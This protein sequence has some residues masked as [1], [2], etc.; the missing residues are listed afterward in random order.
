[1]SDTSDRT[2]HPDPELEVVFATSQ[3]DLLPVIKS[4]L[5]GTDIPYVVDGE[6]MMNLFPSD[7]LGP[8]FHR[9]RGE[10]R[11]LVPHDRAEE[12]RELLRTD[13]AADDAASVPSDATES[14][15]GD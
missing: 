13:A 8:T 6:S 3:A 11:F 5:D 12:A 15:A 10:A 14:T 1:M 4:L 7:M 9:P 2:E